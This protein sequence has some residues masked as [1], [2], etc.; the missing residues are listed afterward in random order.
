MVF[1]KQ[2]HQ[3]RGQVPMMPAVTSQWLLQEALTCGL[4]WS[5]VPAV[6]VSALFTQFSVTKR[7]PWASIKLRFKC[8]LQI[9]LIVPHR[10][11]LI[12]ACE[13]L[14]RFS[15]WNSGLYQEP[16]PSLWPKMYQIKHFLCLNHWSPSSAKHL[17]THTTWSITCSIQISTNYMLK[18][19]M[20]KA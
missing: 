20:S 8:P 13:E 17:T 14:R 3:L 6:K 11:V 10:V 4:G 18:C 2:L 12:A 7:I 1:S 19:D 16:H 9:S 15:H 5:A